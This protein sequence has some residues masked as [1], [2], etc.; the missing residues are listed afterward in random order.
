MS[1][2]KMAQNMQR[3]LNEWEYQ[4]LLSI[5]PKHLTSSLSLPQNIVTGFELIKI[6]GIDWIHVGCL[7]RDAT[8]H[9]GSGLGL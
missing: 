2:R 5:C 8:T 1:L 4:R 6:A 9:P 3:I 7:Q